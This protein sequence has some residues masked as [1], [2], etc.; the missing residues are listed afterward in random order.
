MIETRLANN[1]LTVLFDGGE[2]LTVWHPK[3]VE[4]EATVFRIQDA[5]RVRWEWFYYSR[6]QL[7]KNRFFLEYSLDGGV[8]RGASNVDWYVP[9]F[10]TYAELPAAELL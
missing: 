7:P 5:T 3:G 10:L 9:R 2:R 6:P 1:R 8:V 4:I